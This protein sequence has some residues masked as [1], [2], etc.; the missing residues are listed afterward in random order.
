MSGSF[1]LSFGGI[2]FC[3]DVARVFRM[4]SPNVP[5]QDAEEQIPLRKHQPF[6]DVVDEL[7]R[8]IP[9]Q[10]LQEFYTPSPFPGRNLAGIASPYQTSQPSPNIRIGDWYYPT[11]ASRWGVFRGLAMSSMVEAMLKATQGSNPQTFIMKAV[12]K[13]PGNFREGDYTLSTP[14]Y[15]LPPRPLAEHGGRFDGLYLV[16]LVDERYYFQNSPISLHVAYGTTWGDLLD[17][18][19]LA[20]G[21]TLTYSTIPDAYTQPEPDSPLWSNMESAPL[22]LDA[23]AYN[24]GRVVVR[25]LDGSYT[26]KTPSESQT[27]VTSNRGNANTVVRT[28]GG[29]LF[30]SGSLIPGNAAIPDLRNSRNSVVPNTVRVSFPQ[31]VVGNDPVP[32]FL[33]PRYPNQRP[34]CWH[35]DSFGSVYSVDVPITSGGIFVSG[36]SGVNTKTVIHSTA[37]ALLSGEIATTPL[38]QSGLVSLAMQVAGDYYGSQVAAAL[39]ETYPGTFAWSPEGF[40]DI[41][42]TYSERVRQGTTRVLRT[43]WNQAVT[44]MQHHTPA[45]SGSTGTPKGVGG[46][47]VAQTIRTSYSGNVGATLLGSGTFAQ[48]GGILGSGDT[49]AI[50]D[51]IGN[52]PTQ[53]RW[54]GVIDNETILFEGTSGGVSGG[55]SGGVLVDIA[56]RGIDGSLIAKHN[57]GAGIN[58]VL[59]DTVYGVNLT[60][61]EKGQFLYPQEW[62]S[63]GIQGLR[64]VPQT[65]TIRCFSASGKTIN[66]IEHWSGAV[67]LYDAT[68]QSGSQ[69]LRRE[70]VW[71]VERNGKK[72]TS[73][74]FYDGQL[75]GYATSGYAAPIYAAN[76]GGGVTECFDVVSDVFC[77]A[78]GLHVTVITECFNDGELTSVG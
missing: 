34:S 66:T 48:G 52:L 25:N 60:T 26:L 4:P 62:T 13:G 14:L 71:L 65:Q 8:L 1:E 6:T 55:L 20:L 28:A 17:S 24:L 22:L 46:P 31:Y 78:S 10:Y 76:K 15:M 40:H 75:V 41:V 68:Q 19:A 69:W 59:P 58:Q 33:N 39:D 7:N 56:L 23:V 30:N 61:F 16:T 74:Q 37:K 51:G 3:S 67:H 54:R 47:S 9:F 36:L 21:I 11:T 72:F 38:N 57:S 45:A 29:D 35:E 2:P 43:E 77:D 63:G 18:L 32:H 50:F 49:F 27:L 5:E 42:W 12:P 70:L 44:E 53:N 73:G 64:V